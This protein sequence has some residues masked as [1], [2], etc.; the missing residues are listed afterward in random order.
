MGRIAEA[1][2]DNLKAYGISARDSKARPELLDL[3]LFYNVNFTNDWEVS[4][5]A[6]NDGLNL[7]PGIHRL[8]DV[9][10]DVRGVIQVAPSAGHTKT[11]PKEVPGIPVG[12]ALARIHFLHAA[13]GGELTETNEVKAGSYMVHYAD[14]QQHE[15]PLRLG[16]ELADWWFPKPTDAEV[17][18]TGS[19]S[20]SAYNGKT[21]QLFKFT[22]QNP[23]PQVEVR[24]LDLISAMTNA[25][26]FVV[27]ITVE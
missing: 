13:I 3:S 5:E 23:R 8:V 11:L 9:D 26:P 12:H 1:G 14:G 24:S 27:A 2:E 21:V 25:A 17:A 10:F 20:R 6:R 4:F 16:K 15:I 7:S 22:W 18:W 19:N